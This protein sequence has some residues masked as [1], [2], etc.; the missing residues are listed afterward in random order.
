[1]AVL[2]NRVLF[3]TDTAGTGT[4]TVGSAIAGYRG[5][6][7]AGLEDGNVVS[8]AIEDGTN[9]EVGRG[10]IGNGVTT[11]TRA[12]LA[13]SSAGSAISLSGDARVLLTAL[14]EDFEEFA[15][16]D[17]LGALAFEDVVETDLISDAAVTLAKMASLVQARLLGRASGAGTGA[18]QAIT[19][20]Q[21]KAL[22]AIAAGDVSGL[23]ALAALDQVDTAQIV[24]LAVTSAKIAANAVRNV[25]LAQ[26][27]EARVKGRALGA[28]TGDPEDLTG[29][30]LS[31]ILGLGLL[32]FL[33]TVGTAQLDNL[34]VTSAKIAANAVRNVEL[35]TMA[36]GTIKGRAASGTGNPQDLSAANVRTLL[37]VAN[38]AETNAYRSQRTVG[39]GT[40]NSALGDEMSV[41]RVELSND[42]A[43]T[44]R[45]N[46]NVAHST[47]AWIDLFAYKMSGGG[48]A[49][50]TIT[51]INGDSIRGGD[52]LAGVIGVSG[53]AFVRCMKVGASVWAVVT[54]N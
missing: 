49:T 35:S 31:T 3:E 12:V 30:Q 50:L 41:V 47:L 40:T 29:A 14:A 24:G 2:V 26:M 43:A 10:T 9:F 34:A 36:E 11:M 53:A 7:D 27:V 54:A 45:L 52:K 48:S 51:A 25:E 13:S 32:A 6:A 16:A 20:A 17:E 4:L 33:D 1:V 28:G 22:L 42:E 44:Y 19:A 23:G 5:P 38:G 46:G 37:N 18:P 15:L 39:S 21:A 8:Y